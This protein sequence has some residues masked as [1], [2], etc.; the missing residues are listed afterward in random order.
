MNTWVSFQ[1]AEQPLLGQFSVSDNIYGYKHTCHGVLH[2]GWATIQAVVWSGWL[3]YR[4]RFCSVEK[5]EN[6]AI[7]AAM[8]E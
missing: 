5:P 7:E 3:V 4:E 6:R 2:I 1:S 8:S